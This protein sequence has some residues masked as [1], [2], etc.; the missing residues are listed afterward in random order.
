[1]GGTA[2]GQ[3][4]LI[5]ALSAYAAALAIGEV[6]R[7]QKAHFAARKEL[8]REEKAAVR[9]RNTT[10]KRWLMTAGLVL[11]FGLLCVFKYFHF[12]LAQWNRL[13]AQMG[14]GQI[15]DVFSLAVPLGISFHR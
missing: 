10:R 1:M 9:K 3:Y 8:T 11:N 15:V 13:L 7:R 14:G 6:D 5:T 12:A 2:G 4:I